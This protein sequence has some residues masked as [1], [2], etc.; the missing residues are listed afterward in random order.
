[1]KK[2]CKKLFPPRQVLTIFEQK[3]SNLRPLLS[4]TFPQEFQKYKKLGHWTLE[5]WGKKMF[6]KSEKMIKSMKN[7]FCRGD[8]TP[9]LSKSFQI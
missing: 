8:F 5:S 1:M 3:F 6:K 9:Y 2:I 4:F 7:L